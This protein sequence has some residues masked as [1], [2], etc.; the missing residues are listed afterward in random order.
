MSTQTSV[1]TPSESRKL[2]PMVTAISISTSQPDQ[3]GSSTFGGVWMG[4]GGSAVYTDP[5]G[6]KL[7][8]GFSGEDKVGDSQ[9]FQFSIA[10]CHFKATRIGCFQ[11]AIGN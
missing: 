3:G 5:T 7:P 11:L 1:T 4:E 8:I 2:A 9:D 6:G 10:N